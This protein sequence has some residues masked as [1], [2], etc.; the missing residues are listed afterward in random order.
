MRRARYKRLI[1]AAVILAGLAASTTVKAQSEDM[2]VVVNRANPVS[3]ISLAELRKMFLGEAKF[4][5]NSKTVVT[6]IMRAPGA[7]E[8]D[9]TLKVAFRMSED[10]Y[11]KYWIGRIN[12]GETVSAPAEVFAGGS[13]QG[14]VREVPGA[15]GVVKTSEVRA[16]VKV[17]RIDGHLPGEPG[18]SFRDDHFSTTAVTASRATQ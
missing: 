7:S 8:R 17:L 2:A 11:K 4:W 5:N 13:L 10:E 18:Y 14:L 15:I 9:V 3:S 16:E 6:V 1:L 12:R